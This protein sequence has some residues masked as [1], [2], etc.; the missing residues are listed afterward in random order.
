MKWIYGADGDC[1]IDNG[2][3]SE[4]CD[5]LQFWKRENKAVAKN[6]YDCG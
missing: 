4:K 3:P 6:K 1:A 5:R 2:L